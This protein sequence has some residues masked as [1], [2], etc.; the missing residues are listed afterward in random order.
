MW[1]RRGC[2]LSS[3]GGRRRKTTFPPWRILHKLV[4]I[5]GDSGFT[6]FYPTENAFT[7]SL[8]SSWFLYG[9][10]GGSRHPGESLLGFLPNLTPA[11][12]RRS[13]CRLEVVILLILFAAAIS[14][15]GRGPLQ[16]K[17]IGFPH[18]WDTNLTEKP[19]YLAQDSDNSEC[20][21]RVW[22][23]LKMVYGLDGFEIIQQREKI[24]PPQL[25]KKN[26]FQK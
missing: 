6:L 17:R 11:L 10:I 13:Q 3:R 19:I 22:S 9:A 15:Q 21:R 20:L 16:T 7:Q 2:D 14:L 4:F 25:K 24:L 26:L 18:P 12:E 8:E 5:A 1:P 23:S